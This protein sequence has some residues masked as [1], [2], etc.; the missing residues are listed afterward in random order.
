LASASSRSRP[1]RLNRPSP[2]PSPP[3]SSLDTAAAYRNEESVGRAI[4][5][6]GIPREELFITTKLWV[7][8]PDEDNAKRAFESSLRRLGVDYVDLYLIH[9]P[10]GDYYSSWRAMQNLHRERMIRA[11]GVSNFYPDRLIDL[12][13]HNEITPGR[14][15]D[16]GNGTTRSDCGPSG[17]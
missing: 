10:F 14:Q 4:A 17:Q 3:A 5:R 11:I 2:T 7:H 8:E 9:Q 16:R 15:P 12:I 6:K 13:D 1:S